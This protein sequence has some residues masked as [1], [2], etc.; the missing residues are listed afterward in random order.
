MPSDSPQNLSIDASLRRD[1]ERIAQRSGRSAEEIASQALRD[2]VRYE[3]AVDESVQRGIDD[4]LSGRTRTMAEV[5]DAIATRRRE[6]R[7]A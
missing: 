1:L 3:D 2:F 6:R 4:V 7:T 5:V